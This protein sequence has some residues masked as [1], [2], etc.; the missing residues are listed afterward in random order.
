MRGKPKVG[1]RVWWDDPDDGICSGAGVVT[2]VSGD[3]VSL[4]MDDGGEV[5][6]LRSEV[7]AA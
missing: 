5:E 7:S 2:D 1:T 6:A 3:V 4:L